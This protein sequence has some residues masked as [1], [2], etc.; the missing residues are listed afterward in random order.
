MAVFLQRRQ[1]KLRKI[2]E[3]VREASCTSNKRQL[4]PP[5]SKLALHCTALHSEI[6]SLRPVSNSTQTTSLRD[7]AGW[8][9]H[10][11]THTHTQTHSCAHT[12]IEHKRGSRV[13]RRPLGNCLNRERSGL[14][15]SMLLLDWEETFYR[16]SHAAFFAMEHMN[17]NQKYIKPVEE[18]YKAP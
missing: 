2:Q 17:I 14:G 12:T 8:L 6:S 11:H 5:Q 10:T 7:A 9:A 16:V 4:L 13:G 1:T 3:E 15:A 18:F